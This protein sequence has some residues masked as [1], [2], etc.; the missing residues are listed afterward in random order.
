MQKQLFMMFLLIYYIVKYLLS[1]ASGSW[2]TEFVY[3]VVGTIIKEPLEQVFHRQDALPV[4]QPASSECLRELVALKPHTP[5][6]HNHFT[7]LFPGPP[8]WAGARR[9]LLDFMVQGKINRGRHWPFVWVPLHP[10]QSL[11]TFTIPPFFYR[12]DALPA[13]P[14]NSVKALKATSALG[15]GRRR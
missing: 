3:T 9:E 7:A 4:T 13:P 12:L 11:P 15:L 2:F 5:Q 1:G 14:T 10:D 6:P 8:R